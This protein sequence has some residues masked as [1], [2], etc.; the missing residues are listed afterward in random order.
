MVEFFRTTFPN[1]RENKLQRSKAAPISEVRISKELDAAT[2]MD[3]FVSDHATPD[4]GQ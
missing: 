4:L 2:D 3:K 1:F